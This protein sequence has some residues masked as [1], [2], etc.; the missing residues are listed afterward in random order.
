VGANAGLL[1]NL[2]QG[3]QVFDFPQRKIPRTQ[4]MSFGMQHEFPGSITLD[5]R[6][7]ANYASR[8]RAGITWLNGTLSYA[9]LQYALNSPDNLSQL[10]PNPYYQVAAA[11]SPG[12]CGNFPEVQAIALLLPYPQY[13][14]GNGASLLGQYN[15]P[16][17]RNWYNGMEVKLT[18]RTTHGLEFNLA[19]TYSKNIN[20]DGYQN[21]YPY[22]DANEIHWISPYDRTHVLAVTGVYDLPVGKG[23]SFMATAPRAVDYALGGWSLGW[24]F[25]AQSGTPVGV[26]NGDDNYSCNNWAP[27]HP[28]NVAEW[29]NPGILNC[30]TPVPKIGGTGYTYNTY[31]NVIPQV[32]NP[33]VPNLDLSLQKSFKV[34]ERVSFSLRGE[35]FNSLNSALLEGPNTSVSAGPATLVYNDTTKRSYWSGFGTVGPQPGT[36]FQL[37][38]PRNLRVSGKIIF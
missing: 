13:C 16:V 9:Q 6:W 25:A 2:G 27:P 32:R 34:T 10:V 36:Q 33:T 3:A 22:T 12:A 37:N 8:L 30:A 7:A 35:A 38:F 1:T 5:A 4:Q 19:Y 31:P 15:L 11:S 18:K 17:G 23:R 26:D 29:I 20:G 28:G 21:G 14:S 24:T